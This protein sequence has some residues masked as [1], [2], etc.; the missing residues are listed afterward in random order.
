MVKQV[1]SQV[2]FQK[3]I[4]QKLWLIARVFLTQFKFFVIFE[5]I[6]PYKL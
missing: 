4:Q 3:I 2:I 1:T 6:S 5:G